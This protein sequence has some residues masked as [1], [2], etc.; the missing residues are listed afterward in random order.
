[1]LLRL[2]GTLRFGVRAARRSALAAVAVSI[3]LA[4]A[5]QPLAAGEGRAAGRMKVVAGEGEEGFLDGSPG[6]FRKPIRLARTATGR[7]VVA[8]I[9]NHAIRIVSGDGVVETIAGAPD[10]KGYRDG[11]T[12]EARFASPHGVAV[13]AEGVIAVAEAENH[14]IRLIHPTGKGQAADDLYSRVTTIAGVARESGYRDGPAERALF[15]S[16]HAVVWTPEGAILVADIGN[17]RIR[18]VADGEVSTVAGSGAVGAAD[19]PSLSASLHY[20]M[21][22]ALSIDGILFI[23]DAGSGLIRRW[24]PDRGVDTLPL[25]GDLHTPHGIS[26]GR[27]GTAYVADMDSSTIVSI[28]PDGTMHRVCGTGEPG[29]SAEQLN[30]PA[31]VLVSDGDVWVADLDNHR[32]VVCE[33]SGEV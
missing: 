5:A 14:T 9:F 32:I 10:R 30:R 33:L 18:R 31:A 4:A 22:I 28:M 12:S 15:A 26:L 2:V 16:P 19:G 25:R 23:A 21:D 7:V 27:D 11:D 13:S 17:A 6:R 24:H 3:S 20:P 1:M 8:D 29:P